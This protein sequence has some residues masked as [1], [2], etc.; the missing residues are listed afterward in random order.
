VVLVAEPVLATATSRW[1]WLASH[2]S[3]ALLGSVVV[4]VAAGLGEGLAYGPS[5]SDAGQI[6]RLIGSRWSICP[7]CGW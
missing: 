5:S 4:L 7:R 1:A 2:L 3:V 6:P